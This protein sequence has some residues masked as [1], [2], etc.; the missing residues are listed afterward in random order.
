MAFNC[1]E[2]LLSNLEALLTDLNELYTSRS[3]IKNIRNKQET[4]D[5]KMA[6][7]FIPALDLSFL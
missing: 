3:C 6:Q 7:R 5:F 1:F 2:I 4:F